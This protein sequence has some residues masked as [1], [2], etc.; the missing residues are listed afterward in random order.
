MLYW[1]VCI[2]FVFHTHVCTAI[3]EEDFIPETSRWDGVAPHF[4]LGPASTGRV[5][6]CGGGFAAA[7]ACFPPVLVLLLRRPAPTCR[8]L[9]C[10][11]LLCWGDLLPRGY[12]RETG[13]LPRCCFRLSFAAVWLGKNRSVCWCRNCMFLFLSWFYGDHWQTCIPTYI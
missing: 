10:R 2:W 7:G 9:R 13:A 3:T 1:T 6:L 11:V 5:L 4:G 8:V 12:H